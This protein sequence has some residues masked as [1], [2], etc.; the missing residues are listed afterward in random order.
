MSLL[1]IDVFW[2]FKGSFKEINNEV[3]KLPFSVAHRP[4]TAVGSRSHPSKETADFFD[5]LKKEKGEVNG[6]YGQFIENMFQQRGLQMCTQD[7]HQPW[8]GIPQQDKLLN[9]LVEYLKM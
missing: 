1:K 6:K 8:N 3:I 4:Y 9:L 7:L 2:E 5:Q